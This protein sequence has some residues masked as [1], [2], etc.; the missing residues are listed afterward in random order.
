MEPLGKFD[1]YF[2]CMGHPGTYLIT[3]GKVCIGD[4]CAV[5]G[6]SGAKR[7]WPVLPKSSGSKC[8]LVCLSCGP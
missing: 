1:L 4:L 5:V 8:L 3:P 7:K 2:L 6:S